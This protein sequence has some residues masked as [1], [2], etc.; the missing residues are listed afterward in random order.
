MF[1]LKKL[2]V[3][4]VTGS[5]HLYGE[6]TLRQVAE[7]AQTIARALDTSAKIPVRVVFKPVVKTPDE[8]YQ[9]C[10]AS[11]TDPNCIGI[12]VASTSK[13]NVSP[14]YTIQPRHTLG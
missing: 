11:N 5:Q 7:H 1:D 4:F 3:W 10:Q 12:V 6:E 14:A 8:I 2:E 13:T 9:L